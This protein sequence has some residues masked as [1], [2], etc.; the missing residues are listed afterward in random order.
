M[1]HLIFWSTVVY[2]NGIFMTVS[3]GERHNYLAIRL[4]RYRRNDPFMHAPGEDGEYV[5][6]VPL[7]ATFGNIVESMDSMQSMESMA[8]MVTKESMH[9]WNPWKKKG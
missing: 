5:F 7:M 3:P 2:G 9:P 8:S 1:G 4:S 6:A